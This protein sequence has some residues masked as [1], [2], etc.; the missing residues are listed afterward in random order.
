MVEENS[1]NHFL[2]TLD[3]LSFWLEVLALNLVEKTLLMKWEKL[4]QSPLKI[5]LKN[6]AQT[7]NL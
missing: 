7:P 6:N 3:K 5:F 2:N 1:K 4:A